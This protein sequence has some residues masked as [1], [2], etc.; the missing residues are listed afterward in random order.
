M[1]EVIIRNS[2]SGRVLKID[3]LKSSKN[4]MNH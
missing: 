3:Y 4:G 1:K 2:E